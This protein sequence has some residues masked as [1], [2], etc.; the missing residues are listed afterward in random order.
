MS[1][2]TVK[3]LA[4]FKRHKLSDY[5]SIILIAVQPPAPNMSEKNGI[6]SNKNLNNYWFNKKKL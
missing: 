1:C 4:I 3:T 5:L 6:R 2:L